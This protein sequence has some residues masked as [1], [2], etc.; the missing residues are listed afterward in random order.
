M[1]RMR[2]DRE[3]NDQGKT[4]FFWGSASR[5]SPTT[6]AYLGFAKVGKWGDARG[7]W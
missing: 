3:N 1:R 6:P 7:R 2:I 4:L 5:S